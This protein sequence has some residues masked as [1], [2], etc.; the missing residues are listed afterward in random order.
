[1]SNQYN[2]VSKSLCVHG[3]SDEF[4]SYEY[5]KPTPAVTKIT[6][7]RQIIPIK[8]PSIY[9]YHDQAQNKSK[10][11]LTDTQLRIN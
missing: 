11:K 3:K 6:D 7:S 4:K 2:A 5:T 8:L 1:M 9:R 10:N